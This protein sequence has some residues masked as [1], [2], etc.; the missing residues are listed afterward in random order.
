MTPSVPNETRDPHAGL[1]AQL[2]DLLPSA[3]LDG[4]L[5]RDALLDAPRTDETKPTFSL[6]WPGNERAFQD[7]RVSVGEYSPDWIIAYDEHGTQQLYL[8]PE[9]KDTRNLDWNEAR[10][11][12]FVEHPF[13]VAAVGSVDYDCATDNHALLIGGVGGED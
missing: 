9:A 1:L 8:V 5:D 2:R 3:F 13:D 6:S 12:R 7:E 4:D 11:I 10:R